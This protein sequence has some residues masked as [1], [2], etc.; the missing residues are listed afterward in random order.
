MTCPSPCHGPCG[1]PRATMWWR[2]SPRLLTDDGA[3]VP[4]G[5]RAPPPPCG[6]PGAT[7]WWRRSLRLLTDDVAVIRCEVRARHH[8]DAATGRHGPP[9]EPQ[10]RT[11]VR[12]PVVRRESLVHFCLRTS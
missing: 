8:G 9:R 12:F 5:G 1:G 7:M 10:A 2:R 6:G 3:G 4:G 11:V